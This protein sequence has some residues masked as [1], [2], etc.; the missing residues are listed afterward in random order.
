MKDLLS[1]FRLI[2]SDIQ[3]IKHL[4]PFLFKKG[5]VTSLWSLALAALLYASHQPEFL[6]LICISAYTSPVRESYKKWIVLILGCY[7]GMAV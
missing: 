4:A 6:I 3:G 5:M 1:K 7:A 2:I